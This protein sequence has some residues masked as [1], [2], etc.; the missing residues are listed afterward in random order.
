MYLSQNV[1]VHKEDLQKQHEQVHEYYL[2]SG[3]ACTACSY[4]LSAPGCGEPWFPH[5]AVLLYSHLGMA[6]SVMFV[7]LVLLL[8]TS[9]TNTSNDTMRT[10]LAQLLTL[11]NWRS[12]FPFSVCL[13]C[14]AVRVLF[15]CASRFFGL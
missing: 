12:L 1:Q 15:G 4:D 2:V 14:F 8:F 10:P 11:H 7:F 3:H 5:R 13:V 6:M 9:H